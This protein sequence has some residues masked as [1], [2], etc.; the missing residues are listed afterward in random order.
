MEMQTLDYLSQKA[1]DMLTFLSYINGIFN[2]SVETLA[3]LSTDSIDISTKLDQ[4]TTYLQNSDITNASTLVDSIKEIVSNDKVI[5]D[6]TANG[7]A[8]VSDH[9]VAATAIVN[10]LIP[11]ITAAKVAIIGDG[12]IQINY[13]CSACSILCTKPLRFEISDAEKHHCQLDESNVAN[14]V[15]ISRGAYQG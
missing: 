12:T 9:I 14:F 4:V 11:M 10:E 5:I 13:K 7:A 1:Q 15:E 6:V 3:N 2:N 8:P